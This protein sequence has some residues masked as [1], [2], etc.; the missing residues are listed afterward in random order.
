MIEQIKKL[1]DKK[2]L[3]CF[4]IFDTIVSRKCYPDYTKKL[5]VKYLKDM[6]KLKISS[7]S[8]Y[9][10]RCSYEKSLCDK[11]KI[12]YGDEEFQYKDLVKNLYDYLIEQKL[13][14][15]TFD[16]FLDSCINL[17][18]GIEKSVQFV[19]AD[20]LELLE[21]CKAKNKKVICISDMYLSKEMLKEIFSYH[22]ILKYFDDIYVSCEYYK[23]KRTGSLYKYVLDD[24]KV[25]SN[26]VL[27]IGDNLYA[28]HKVAKNNGIT[29]F[30][31]CHKGIVDYYDKDVEKHKFDSFQ[32]NLY[33]II[34]NKY[35]N[36]EL[37]LFKN[38]YNFIW[39]LF[40]NHY[41]KIYIEDKNNLFLPRFKEI[42]R[43][44]FL[45]TD[46]SI[47]SDSKSEIQV[48]INDNNIL[49]KNKHE[50]LFNDRFDFKDNDFNLYR[51]LVK[52]ILNEF[53]EIEKIDNKKIKINKQVSHKIEYHKNLIDQGKEYSYFFYRFIKWILDDC[54]EK[55]IKKIYFFTR[56][57][58]FFKILADKINDDR[59]LELE[60]L[61]VS[62]VA[63]F[64]PSITE[65]SVNEM[66]R[67]WNLYS[68][69]SM[70][71]FCKSLDIKVDDIVKYLDKYD[72]SINEEIYRPY[73]D[74]RVKK[75]FDDR[76]FIEYINTEINK[77]KEIILKYFKHKGLENIKQ[78]IAI[79]DIGWRGTIQDNISYIL[80]NTT[81]YG[82][83]LGLNKFFNI[84]PKNVFKYGFLNQYNGGEKYIDNVTPLEMI[85]N[86]P[87][88]SVVGYTSNGAEAIRKIDEIENESYNNYMQYLQKG[89][90]EN[91]NNSEFLNYSDSKIFEILSEIIFNPNKYVAEAYFN[92]KHNEEFGVG[93]YI[94]KRRKFKY[95]LLLKS[96][97][98][99]K[100]R[101]N[102]R[103]DLIDSTWPQGY[104]KISHLGVLN[105][106][107]KSKNYKESDCRMV[108]KR[109]AWFIPKP[110]KGSG[111][112]RTIIQNANMLVKKGYICDLYLEED[113]VSTSQ[114]MKKTI[115]DYFGECLCDVYIGALLRRDYDL[116][117]ATHAIATPEF[118]KY[119]NC[120][121]KAYFIQDFEPWFMPMGETYITMENSYKYNF[122]GV[123]IG[124]WLAYKL[125]NEYN[126]NM[127]Y[128]D[129]CADLNIYKPLDMER[130]KAIC[131]IFQPEKPRRCSNLGLAA[132]KIVKEL[133]PDVKIYL[134]GSPDNTTA[135]ECENLHIIKLDQCNELYNKCSV[136]LCISASNPSRIPFEMMAAGL[137]VVDLYKENNLYDM[138]DSGILL[139]D[140]TP[141][142]IATALLRIL[143][144]KKLAENMSKNG[145]KYMKSYPLEKGYEQF[146][147]SV[148]KM[149]NKEY[150]S[151][152]KL[153][154]IYNK[155]PVLPSDEVMEVSQ[156]MVPV[157]YVRETSPFVRK[158]VRIKKGMVRRMRRII[159]K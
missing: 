143:D 44:I 47:V 22:S 52:I 19:Q 97:F 62:R 87:N 34:D 21:Y 86:S 4:D 49:A 138:P 96:P 83:Y 56:E 108:T 61:E 105:K 6:Y 155:E 94:D 39:Y 60:V 126:M 64:C 139:A 16:E 24:L 141:E 104:L 58:E 98:S 158:L 159:G 154:K 151:D 14:A 13:I 7:E 42:N 31:I 67:I 73:N 124:K 54:K 51:K 109:I 128:F 40:L 129:F 1:I 146:L 74:I 130:E 89:I 33:S 43:E 79:V 99:S 152:E 111:G 10:L 134:Y 57:G 117:F 150:K 107:F 76:Q 144:D 53:Y 120:K 91:I 147:D 125:H 72:L 32:K 15:I 102:F 18:V 137:P 37:K 114:E 71:S 45:K 82:Y 136:G 2:D 119:C 101:N 46:I 118:V 106:Y 122:K 20:T 133:R 29:A 121:N 12:D 145:I 148:D 110:I 8:L 38:C 27:M 5:F 28:D 80:D 85:C 153:E 55:K 68:F 103:K 88:G 41:K 92:L 156:M 100:F 75:L 84:Q 93:A 25:D 112:H 157:P 36:I 123:S 59:N 23:S 48:Y 65:V 149:F 70:S 50:V 30:Q 116:V 140:S 135:V 3:I 63:T 81:I 115:I 11:S 9:D 95:G 113:F 26:N 35:Y 69:Q 77:R 78:R 142:A 17:E 66:R 127:R 131:F 132:L 90:V